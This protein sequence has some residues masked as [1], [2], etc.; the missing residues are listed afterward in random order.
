MQREW[1]RNILRP[2]SLLVGLALIALAQDAEGA[3]QTSDVT[4]QDVKKSISE[5]G[6]ARVIVRLRAAQAP[7]AG[8]RVSGNQEVQRQLDIAARQQRIRNSLRGTN[9]SIRREF[10]SLPYLVVEVDAAGLARLQQATGDVAQIVEDSLFAPTLA[11][12]IPQIEADVAHQHGYDGSGSLIAIIDT[13]VDNSH[14]FLTGKVIDE[15]CFADRENPQDPGSCPNGGTE[16]FGTGAG[17]PCVFAPANCRHGT[18]V[19]GI[20]AGSGDTPGVAPAANLISIQ[21]FHASNQCNGTEEVPCARAFGS[22]ITAALERVYEQRNTGNIASVNMS[23]G[24]PLSSSSCDAL[25]PEMT[26]AIN[27]LKAARIATVVASG[28][29]ASVGGITWPACIQAAIAVGAVDDNDNVASFSNVSQDLDLFAPGVGIVSSIPGGG[30]ESLSGTSM[31]TPHVAGAWAIMRQANP[32]ASVAEVL[33]GLAETGKPIRDGRSG[34]TVTRPRIRLGAALGI[35]APAP[36]LLSLSPSS[37][38]AWTQGGTL[39]LIGSGFVRAS[40]VNVNGV[41]HPATY[42]S[43][44]ELR[45]QVS[46]TDLETQATSIPVAVVTLPPG[47]GTSATLPLLLTYPTLSVDKTAADPGS[48][49]TVTVTNGTGSSGAWIGLAPVGT[50]DTYYVNWTYIGAGQTSFV[51]S[52]NMPGTPRDYEF[53]LFKGAYTRIATS[54]TIA[55]GPAQP[56]NPPTLAVS[57]TTAQIGQAVT[58]TLTNGSGSGSDGIALARVGDPDTSYFNWTYV[59]AGQTSFV[60]TV[61][62]PGTPG[63]YEFRLFKNGFTRVATSPKI[64]VTSAQPPPQPGTPA[65]AVSVTTAQTGQPVTVT[66]TNGSGSGGEWIALAPVGTPDSYYLNWT[67]VPAGQTTFVWTVNMPGTPNNYEFRLFKG[68]YTRAATSPKIAVTAAQPANPPVLAVNVTV[69]QAGQPVI[70]TLTNATS[71]GNDWIG[72][73]PVGTPDSYYL[74]W[75]YVPAGQTTFVWTVNMPGTPNNY[76][77]R[78]FKG[79]YTRV[80]TSPTVQ[81]VP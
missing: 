40:A 44:T 66:L 37:M 49:V 73:A 36:V 34:G 6:R 39:T 16:Q 46:N 80:A 67:Y 9:H 48:P 78:L 75:T 57:I 64:T 35:E 23:L 77:F 53:R 3:G 5:H 4:S 20:A 60:W 38:R 68:G 8:A 13:G 69:V 76:E 17:A 33:A 10:R 12:S 31:A 47:G 7:Q 1:L 81:V 58:V 41:A 65:L 62:M 56:A 54:P 55:V 21:V 63:D 11:D 51:W 15:A 27:A 71:S 70:V 25:L 19:A 79:G 43:A 14:P 22:D 61:N 26:D 30:F 29:S 50:P 72:L 74:N 18:H 2:G 52:A 24:G 45:V 28:N 32:S 42:V 59:S